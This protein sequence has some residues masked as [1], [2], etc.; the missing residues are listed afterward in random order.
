M[1]EAGSRIEVA[2]VTVNRVIAPAVSRLSQQ[3]E[4]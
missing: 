4:N 2:G 1:K 3:I